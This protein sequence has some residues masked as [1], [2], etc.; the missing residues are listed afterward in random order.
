[1]WP[2]TIG[3]IL[4]IAILIERLMY[5]AL[6]YSPAR[7]PE[8][9]IGSDG[10][11]VRN[12][13]ALDR[14]LPDPESRHAQS[15]TVLLA[16]SLY[17]HKTSGPE[18]RE[19]IV[20]RLGSKLTEQF[21][22]RI[23]TLHLI[24]IL[25]PLFGLLGTVAGMMNAFQKI[26]MAEGQPEIGQLAEGIYIAMITTGY[27]LMASIPAHLAHRFLKSYVNRI[28][29]RLNRIAAYF[30]ETSDEAKAA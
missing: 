6:R 29:A 10:V 15:P 2:I 14:L 1:M 12:S 20:Q 30:E 25:A 23:E 19:A 7:E 3:L 9:L 27:G 28:I 13:S 16:K 26:A 4:I 21:S 11:N 5:F 24:A 8:D 22:A 17:Q 18:V